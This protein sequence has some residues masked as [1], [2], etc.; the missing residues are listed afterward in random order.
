V[1]SVLAVA[2]FVPGQDDVDG[3]GGDP[4]FRRLLGGVADVEFGL[5]G[6]E[7]VAV[8]TRGQQRRQQHVA[9]CTHAPVERERSHTG[10]Q[11]TP[12]Q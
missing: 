8:G 4:V 9:A 7:H 2:V 1:G 6:R 5:D 3:G 11:A 10:G 12:D